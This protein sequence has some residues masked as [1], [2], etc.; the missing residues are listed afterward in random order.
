MES[1]EWPTETSKDDTPPI[2][3]ACGEIVSCGCTKRLLESKMQM[4]KDKLTVY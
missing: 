2:P 3:E 4:S 1:S